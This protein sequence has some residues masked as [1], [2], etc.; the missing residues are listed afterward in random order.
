MSASGPDRQ[1]EAG[2][3]KPGRNPVTLFAFS[4]QKPAL[5]ERHRVKTRGDGHSFRCSQ[6]NQAFNKRLQDWIHKRA[7]LGS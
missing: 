6:L 7:V 5:A 1:V 4:Y 2:V 3:S